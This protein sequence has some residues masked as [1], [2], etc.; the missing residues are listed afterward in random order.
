M[1]PQPPPL[2]YRLLSLL[3]LPFWLIHALFHG[4]SNRENSYLRQRVGLH[5]G[6]EPA[7]IWVHAA[8]VGEVAL[9][10]P[11]VIVLAES[12]PVTVTTFTASGYQHARRVLPGAVLVQILPIDNWFLARRFFRKHH[13]R[14]ALIA[15]TEL[16]P[17]FLYRTRLEGIPLIQINARISDKTLRSARWVQPILRRSL[18]YFDRFLTRNPDDGERLQMLGVDPA[19]IRLC[20]NLKSAARL[21]HHDYPRLIEVPYLLFASTHAPEELALVE[22]MRR[23]DFPLLIVI[24]PRH[25]KRADDIVRDLASAG[26]KLAR[27]SKND[28]LTAETRIYLADTLGELRAFMQHAEIVIMGGSF[29]QVG[30]HNVLEP[31]SLGKATITGPSDSNISTDLDELLQHEAIIQV[32]NYS[33]LQ[34]ALVDLLQHPEA[35]EQ[36]GRNATAA[37]ESRADVLNTYLHQIDDYLV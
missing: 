33:D 31:T 22:V 16:W 36:L 21:E 19:R 29:T 20:G 17:E 35:R 4:S 37:N 10:E 26:L 6:A 32:Q 7:A 12:V 18:Q 2:H 14:L 3:L 5:K 13:F 8:S 25:P 34:T 11:L 28:A 24:A 9:I 30:G 27:R 15:E 1:T 23:L